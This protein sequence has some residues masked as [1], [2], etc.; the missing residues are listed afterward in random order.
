[1]QIRKKKLRFFAEFRLLEKG[2]KGKKFNIK[3]KKEEVKQVSLDVDRA[4]RLNNVAS[5][6]GVMYEEVKEGN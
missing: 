5:G 2:T 6:T 1:M 3:G 4:K